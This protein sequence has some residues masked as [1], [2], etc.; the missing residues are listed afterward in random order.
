MKKKWIK[1]LTPLLILLLPWCCLAT[2]DQH[3]IQVRYVKE[4]LI[5]TNQ[6]TNIFNLASAS[7]DF[8]YFGHVQKLATADRIQNE[9]KLIYSEQPGHPGTK[10][11]SIQFDKKKAIIIKPQQSFKLVMVTDKK[12]QPHDLQIKAPTPVNVTVNVKNENWVTTISICN[13][14]GQTIPLT[15]LEFSFNYARTMPTNIWGSPWVG[16]RLADQSGS[17][18]LL[19]GG[20]PWSPSFPNDPDCSNPLTLNF[21]AAPSDPLPT[22]PFVFKA[23]GGVAPEKGS[24]NVE[25]GAAPASGLAN[26]SLTVSGPGT[27]Q[28]RSIAWGSTWRVPNLD[29]GS[30]TVTGTSVTSGG[31]SYTVDPVSVS[32]NN[33]Q[34]AT[35]R[36]NY[37]SGQTQTGSVTVNL[38]NAPSAEVP[39][40]LTGRNNTYN[41]TATNGTVWTLPADT[42]TVSSSITGYTTTINPNPLVVPTNKTLGLTYTQESTGTAGSRTINFVNQCPFPVWFGFISGATPN[43]AGGTCNSDADCYPGST[44]VNRGGGSNQCFWKTPVPSNG[45]FRLAPN[46]GNNSVLLPYVET[47]MNAVYSGAAA[48]RTNC[49]ASGCETADC[50]AGEG[51]CPAGRGFDQPSSQIEFTLQTNALDYYNLSAVNGMNLPVSMQP[52]NASYNQ[53]QPYVCGHPGNPIARGRIGACSWEFSPPLIE[54]YKVREGGRA[55]S[56][57]SDCSGDEYC[58]L[59]FNP[60]KSPLLQ[61]TCGKLIGYWN[62]NQICAVQRSYGAPFNCNEQLPAPNEAYRMFNLLGCAPIPSCYQ[63]NTGSGCCGCVDWDKLGI[64]IP[65]APYTEQCKSSNPFWVSRVRPGLEWVKRGCPTIYTYPYDDMSSTFVCR[66][67]KEGINSTNY[68]ITFCPG[69]KTAGL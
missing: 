36:L 13:K 33:G 17:Q 7:I 40:T 60:G 31:T 10:H 51:G 48:G 52:T 61:K 56:S 21:N 62:A 22:G 5:I 69:G 16:W 49:T 15:D 57:R 45:N 65:P 18:V 68:T 1:F 59:S 41:R 20:T 24:L 4:A 14:S 67:N 12:D 9:M 28:E 50:G 46:G 25:L 27:N 19:I 11:Y 43:R 2:N 64:P 3:H 35:A 39:V 32:I 26:P 44:C 30:Y 63:P 58:G 54:Y 55:C 42:Y 23:E 47:P 37:K 6:S 38:T 66:V 34:T 29:A 8:D 53:E